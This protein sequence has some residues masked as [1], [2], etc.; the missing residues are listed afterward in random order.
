MAMRLLP[1]PPSGT[2]TGLSSAVSNGM[3]VAWRLATDCA[4]VT[5]AELRPVL[6]V[7]LSVF[8]VGAAYVTVIIIRWGAAPR[9]YA[10]YRVMAAAVALPARSRP[11]PSSPV[12]L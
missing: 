2:G 8:A 11:F 4:S 1:F 6:D 9:S 3:E 12:C 7:L 5:F 10:S